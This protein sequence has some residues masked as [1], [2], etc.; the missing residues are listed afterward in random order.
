MLEEGEITDLVPTDPFNDPSPES[1][2]AKPEEGGVSTEEKSHK[3]KRYTLQK[4]LEEIEFEIPTKEGGVQVW[5]AQIRELDGED[6]DQYIQKQETRLMMDDKGKIVGIRPLPNMDLWVCEK[7]LWMKKDGVWLLVKP[8][9]VK[10]I[11]GSVRGEI[12]DTALR[13]SNIAKTMDEPSQKK[14][15]EHAK[16]D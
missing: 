6:R 5:E 3:K 15:Y 4:N 10:Q 8:A 9:F 7:C 2:F 14:V 13:L 1:I 11:P 16:N 12:M